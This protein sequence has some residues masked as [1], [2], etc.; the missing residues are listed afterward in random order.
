MLFRCLFKDFQDLICKPCPSFLQDR[1]NC[2]SCPQNKCSVCSA[3][4]F[5]KSQS[6]TSL[7]PDSKSTSDAYAEAEYFSTFVS[8]NT[9]EAEVIENSQMDSQD[10]FAR[11]NMNNSDEQNDAYMEDKSPGLTAVKPSKRFAKDKSRLLLP[12]QNINAEYDREDSWPE[13][14][15][16]PDRRIWPNQWRMWNQESLPNQPQFSN[17]RM[18][19]PLRYRSGQ[20]QEANQDSFIGNFPNPRKFANMP[21][22]EQ[23]RI[24]NIEQFRMPNM[25]NVDQR[26]MSNM[27]SIDQRRMPNMPNIDQRIMPNMPNMEKW[28]LPKMEQWE[29]PNQES[30]LDQSNKKMFSALR[31]RR[32]LDIDESDKYIKDINDSYANERKFDDSEQTTNNPGFEFF[33]DKLDQPLLASMDNQ[34][35]GIEE[36]KISTQKSRYTIYEMLDTDSETSEHKM[37]VKKIRRRKNMPILSRFKNI[38][39]SVPKRNPVLWKLQSLNDFNQQEDREGLIPTSFMDVRNGSYYETLN[40]SDMIFPTE[41]ESQNVFTA[42]HTVFIDLKP[43]DN[44]LFSDNSLNSFFQADEIDTNS[45]VTNS[46]DLLNH[47][48]ALENEAKDNFTANKFLYSDTD[49]SG[50]TFQ[51]NKDGDCSINGIYSIYNIE[52]TSRSSVLIFECIVSSEK[53]EIS[54][55]NVSYG[56]RIILDKPDLSIPSAIKFRKCNIDRI[57]STSLYLVNDSRKTISECNNTFYSELFLELILKNIEDALQESNPFYRNSKNIT[58]FNLDGFGM[59][60]NISHFPKP[61]NMQE[62]RFSHTVGN[63]SLRNESN[64]IIVTFPLSEDSTV[65]RL[66]LVHNNFDKPVFNIPSIKD[67]KLEKEDQIFSVHASTIFGMPDLHNYENLQGWDSLTFEHPEN[68]ESDESDSF[69]KRI[70]KPFEARRRKFLQVAEMIEEKDLIDFLSGKFSSNAFIIESHKIN[71]YDF[72]LKQ[73]NKSKVSCPTCEIAYKSFWHSR[74]NKT[75]GLNWNNSY[76]LV[77]EKPEVIIHNISHSLDS[78]TTLNEINQTQAVSDIY[79]SFIEVKTDLMFVPF[80]QLLQPG[81][82]SGLNSEEKIIYDDPLTKIDFSSQKQFTIEDI[83]K[84]SPTLLQDIDQVLFLIFQEMKKQ[85]SEGKLSLFDDDTAAVNELQVFADIIPSTNELNKMGYKNFP[86]LME[87]DDGVNQMQKE[88]LMENSPTVIDKKTN[89][90]LFENPEQVYFDFSTTEEQE[91]DIPTNKTGGNSPFILYSSEDNRTLAINNFHSL[92]EEDLYATDEERTAD[93]LAIFYGKPNASD[94][95]SFIAVTG[96]VTNIKQLRRL[97][98]ELVKAKKAFDV[99][100]VHDKLHA[101]KF[102]IENFLFTGFSKIF[103]EENTKN[104]SEY[105]EK[106]AYFPESL[107]TENDTQT[108]KA[109]SNLKTSEVATGNYEGK[110]IFEGYF[111]SGDSLNNSNDSFS[112]LHRSLTSTNNSDYFVG[113]DFT[114]EPAFV[115]EALTTEKDTQTSNAERT[116]KT[117]SEVESWSNDTYRKGIFEESF[118]TGDSL[119]SFRSPDASLTSTNNSEYSAG[120]DIIYFT[121][122]PAINPEALTTENDTQTSNAESTLK[123]S[124]VGEAGSYD[125]HQKGIFEESVETGDSLNSFRSPYISFTSTNNSEYSDGQDVT[126]FTKDLVHVPVAPTTDNG[127]QTVTAESTLKTSSE[128]EAVTYE[129]FRKAISNGVFGSTGSFN[130]SEERLSRLYKLFKAIFEGKR[131]LSSKELQIEEESSPNEDTENDESKF[132]CFSLNATIKIVC[133]HILDT[134]YPSIR[135]YRYLN[136]LFKM[137][138][139]VIINFAFSTSKIGIQMNSNLI[140]LH[141]LEV[142]CF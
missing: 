55:S 96:N 4:E 63:E 83:I 37:K 60:M 45:E 88:F 62:I 72:E 140:F 107:T 128:V 124:S 11:E 81:N 70:A 27:P 75:D 44:D 86:V 67:I 25:P 84:E 87:N 65:S 29:L 26:R 7:A 16:S 17:E 97:F 105:L 111:G 49:N 95:W 117:S 36:S 119:N 131:E 33:T 47:I 115:K 93:D 116:L 141:N 99:Q 31:Y 137:F 51:E 109:E 66:L 135:I 48:N 64:P 46:E 41:N 28:R 118:G 102:P 38:N 78:R 69:L 54:Q 19:S 32:D 13:E 14:R 42:F 142:I 125:T 85:K 108:A 1:M 15:N 94:D 127:T 130:R 68:D 21:N 100:K 80:D 101:T 106:P 61:S 136:V 8:F 77:M 57:T 90:E 2:T 34:Q 9:D 73:S 43:R 58:S 126:Y 112:S 123:T 104:S 23:W 114:N 20:N 132:I 12:M 129:R 71:F 24:P 121:K 35:V 59:K 138:L 53:I 92:K 74:F 134:I 56:Q 40:I 89:I 139:S 113:L 91:L 120:L 110:E 50:I 18:F 3:K 30:S 39:R 6:S 98:E 82:T 103:K 133:P 76:V 122:E 52:N 5:G 10:K 79:L 22:M